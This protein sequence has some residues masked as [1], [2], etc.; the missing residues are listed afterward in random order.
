M[1]IPPKTVVPTECRPFSP[2]PDASTRGTTPKNESKRCH[3]N[4]AQ[5]DARRLNRRVHDRHP[6]L[7][8]LLREFDNQN[9]ILARKPDQHDESDL[10]VHV[11]LQAAQRLRSSAP[12]SAMGTA[13]ST[14]NG[15]TK[16]SYCAESVR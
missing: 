9:G 16:L 10:A 7:P 5:A 6:A 12:S 11:V 3:Q 1:I 4:G 8:Q 13:S 2:A 15:N 14:M